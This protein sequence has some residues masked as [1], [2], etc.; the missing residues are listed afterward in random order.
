MENTENETEKK[1][2]TRQTGILVGVVL[3][4]LSAV[5]VYIAVSQ[6]K[7][8]VKSETSENITYSYSQ[9]EQENTVA[10]KAS[11]AKTK[12]PPADAETEN[13]DSGRYEP[14]TVNYPID[15]NSCDAEEL[16]TIDGI[17]GTRA[18]AIIA[19]RDYLGGYSSVEQLKNISGIGEATFEKIAP[20]VTVK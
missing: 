13:T 14:D 16:M 4:I 2:D 1:S 15:L 3:I 8:T 10:E 12:T 9:S 19:Y 18:A 20:Y 11:E 5:F 17:G 6:P 7:E